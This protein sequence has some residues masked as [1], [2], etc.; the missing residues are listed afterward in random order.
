MLCFFNYENINVTNT[1][2]C[3]SLNHIVLKLKPRVSFNTEYEFIL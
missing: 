3:N 1:V 2:E